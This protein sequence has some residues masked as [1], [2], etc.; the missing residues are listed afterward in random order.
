MEDDKESD[1][2]SQAQSKHQDPDHQHPEESLQLIDACP[3]DFPVITV[4]SRFAHSPGS[5]RLTAHRCVM[6][7]MKRIS[8]RVR[9]SGFTATLSTEK[10]RS[11]FCFLCCYVCE[12]KGEC[13]TAASSFFCSFCMFGVQK[14]SSNVLSLLKQ[15]R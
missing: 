12:G 2:G 3:V 11:D 7:G 8:E 10:L 9:D 4:L 1:A 13:L 15:R 5:A 14:L 6:S